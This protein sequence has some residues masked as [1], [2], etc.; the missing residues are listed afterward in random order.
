MTTASA[1]P[2]PQFTLDYRPP[3]REAIRRALGLAPNGPEQAAILETEFPRNVVSGGERGGKSFIAA[4]LAAERTFEFDHPVLGW[5]A[6]RKYQNTEEEF[7]YMVDFFSRLGVLEDYAKTQPDKARWMRL[8]DG[9]VF[10]TLS[11]AEE[12]NIG[13]E[14][15]DIIVV[16]EVSQISLEAFKKFRARQASSKGLMIMTGTFEPGMTWFHQVFKAW[17]SGADGSKSFSL[18]SWTNPHVYPGG[19]EDPELVAMER[20]VGEDF[21][22]ERVAGVPRIPE[23]LVFGKDF[24]FDQ[25]IADIE[26][27]PGLPVYLAVDPGYSGGRH[28]ILAIQCPP[29]SPIHVF[30]EIFETKLYTE[31]MID[32]AMAKPWWLD[33]N[34]EWCCIDIQ[35]TRVQQAVHPPVHIWANGPAKLSF[36]SVFVPIASGIDRMKSFL[37]IDP[38]TH[39]PRIVFAPRCTGFLSEVGVVASP[40]TG[41]MQAYSWKMDRQKNLIGQAP[42]N[43]WNDAIKALTYFL[44]K[45]YGFLQPVGSRTKVPGKIW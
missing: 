15:P 8:T 20:D 6:G 34:E 24:S 13:Q 5:I 4:W 42:Q 27:I 26:Y 16:C 12:M 43:R 17:S 44:V 3:G 32:V 11:V 14:S 2:V 31:E 23:G 29:D 1:P 9:S 35:A 40:L 36:H 38:L 22:L 19:R 33:V 25:H 45:K 30:D 41:L 10:K 28:V 37:R 7:D 39:R 18:P 21:F